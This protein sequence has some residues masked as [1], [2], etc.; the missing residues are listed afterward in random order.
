M[1]TAVRQTVENVYLVWQLASGEYWGGAMETNVETSQV[2]T[3]RVVHTIIDK[4][5]VDNVALLVF[6]N[7]CACC[8]T[9]IAM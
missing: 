5:G 1:S 6:Q 8:R 2:M 3:R 9:A 4:E 7:N